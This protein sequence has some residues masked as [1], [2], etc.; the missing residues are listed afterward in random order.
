MR[1]LAAPDKFRGTA[2]AAEVAEAIAMTA[3]DLGYVAET[4]PMA[5]GGEGTLEALG[6]PTETSLVTGPDGQTREVCWRFS[7]GTAVIEMARA[8]GL[9]LLPEGTNNP[10]TATSSGTGQLVAEAFGRG[11]RTVVVTLGGSATT[12]GG[13]G[14]IEAIGRVP[15]DAELLVVCD[16]ETRFT[17]AARDFGPQKGASP[18]QV[19]ELTVRLELLAAHY[20]EKF[21]VDVADLPGAGAAGG[22]AGG[23]VALGGRLVRG[24]DYVADALELNAAIDR[25]DLVVT[26][27]GLMDAQSFSGKV[28][29]GVAARARIRGVPV[30]A[31]VGSIAPGFA[32]PIP[33]CSLVEAVGLEVALTDTLA[34]VRKA[35]AVTFNAHPA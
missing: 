21:G 20:L 22:L 24:F 13:L 12:D 28:V 29:G 15:R 19:L 14:A 25:A 35:A 32:A 2:T 5:D 9:A 6:G 18:A 17:D 1:I 10:M 3:R 23:L 27:E 33:T 11:A 4:L 30:A 26:G 7:E 34:A 8:S 16:V 31:V